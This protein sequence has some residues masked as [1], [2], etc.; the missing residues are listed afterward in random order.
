MGE[1]RENIRTFWEWARHRPTVMVN[2]FGILVIIGGFLGFIIYQQNR[3]IDVLQDWK[4]AVVPTET[5]VINGK[6]VAVFHPNEGL[7]FTSSSRK[8]IDA[9]GTSSRM[10]VCDA[11]KTQ[12]RR[13]IQLDT[14]VA[15]RPVGENTAAENAVVLPDVTQYKGLPRYCKLVIDVVYENVLGTG[16][17]QQEHAETEPFLIE[18][19]VLNPAEIRKEI[20][21]LNKRIKDLEKELNQPASNSSSSTQSQTTTPQNTRNVTNN[22]TNNTNNST[23][24]NNGGNEE[25]ADDGFQLHDLPLLGGLEGIGL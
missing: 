1:T 17:T 23:T 10:I 2:I 25:P 7:V 12:A 8:L 24:N 21:E 15:A 9:K 19:M 4:I 6:T 14:L 22:T 13:E 5:R 3:S 16:R 11:T 20:L 18:E